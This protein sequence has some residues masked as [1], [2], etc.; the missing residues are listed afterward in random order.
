MGPFLATHKSSLVLIVLPQK[1]PKEKGKVID[2]GREG[3]GCGVGGVDEWVIVCLG[4]GGK[5]R[6]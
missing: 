3:E 2:W 1:S 5:K 4:V 6:T